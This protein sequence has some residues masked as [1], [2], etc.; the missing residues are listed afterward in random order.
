MPSYDDF[1]Q[2]VYEHYGVAPERSRRRPPIRWRRHI[3]LF[4]L[5]FASMSLGH[6]WQFPVA[7]MA[8]LLAHEMGHYVACRY[9]GVDA[10]LPYFLPAFPAFIPGL[11]HISWWAGTFGAF[12][13][14]RERIPS[15][16]ALFDI[17]IA[18]PL[19]GFAVCLM[20]MPA[21]ILEVDT[22]I[23]PIPDTVDVD[24][25]HDPL[26]IR[27]LIPLMR[28]VPYSPL[29]ES[30]PIFMAVWWGCFVTLLNLLPIG[31]LDGGHVAYALFGRRY[32]RMAL[33]LLALLWGFV[34]YSG[35][36]L[37]LMALLIT[38][39]G[40]WHPPVVREREGLG[41]MR[42]LLAVIA[43]AVFVACML[44]VRFIEHRPAASPPDIPTPSN[45]ARLAPP[46]P[47]LS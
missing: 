1:A 29:Y 2:A 23:K 42:G 15:R 4:L 12:I 14:I 30:G 33:P 46:A 43:L 24:I 38:M 36:G 10:S 39:V 11:F 32:N 5:T 26:I 13:R 25:I 18:G 8:I 3:V 6:E 28:G 9:Y 21:A 41:P 44:P 22:H 37:L 47:A 17:G 35:G 20:L 31:Q 45:Y 40:P 19:A 16:R 7:L 34:I 27:G